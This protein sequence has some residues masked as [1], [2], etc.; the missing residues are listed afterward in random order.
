MKHE[1]RTILISLLMFSLGLLCMAA[2]S[3]LTRF[4]TARGYAL[5]ALGLVCVCIGAWLMGHARGGK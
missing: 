4:T 2:S 3:F 1:T 5:S